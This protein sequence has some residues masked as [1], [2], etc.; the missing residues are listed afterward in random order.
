[1]PEFLLNEKTG[2]IYESTPLLLRRKHMRTPTKAELAEQ[3]EM[4]GI[5][6]DGAEKPLDDRIPENLR[7]HEDSSGAAELPDDFNPD[8]DV[9]TM[10]K[11]ALLMIGA[12][13]PG[14]KVAA[15]TKVGD[16]RTILQERLDTLKDL[17][18]VDQE[19]PI[20]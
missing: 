6:V 2:M 1:M 7:N 5:E 19:G 8:I 9:S 15:R 10:D 13:I 17:A 11:S 3:A 18:L 16:I 12:K 20:N 4:L 14:F